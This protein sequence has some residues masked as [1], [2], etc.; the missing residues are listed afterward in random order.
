MYPVRDLGDALAQS[1]R[2]IRADVGAEVI[3]VD[4]STWD[5]HT[6]LGT[7]DRGDMRLMID[8]LAR[9]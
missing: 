5:M 1:A 6:G 4:H 7:L 9:S 8:D 3:T 2:V